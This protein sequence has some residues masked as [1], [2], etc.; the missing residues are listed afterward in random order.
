MLWKLL[1]S[2]ILLSVALVAIES[3]WVEY[4]LSEV[5]ALIVAPHGPTPQ[6]ILQAGITEN[7]TTVVLAA[8]DIANC[9]ERSGLADK[10]PNTMYL[11]GF[12]NA[13]D[14][15]S[16]MA[17]ETAAVA[18]EWP[19]AAILALGDTVYSKGRPVEYADCFDPVWGFLKSR[20]LPTPGN[21]EYKT[22][23]AFGYYD[24]FG[25]QAGPERHGW[26]VATAPGWL[27]LSLNS[28]ADASPGSPQSD[29]LRDRL[30]EAGGV[31]ILGF[32]HKPAHSLRARDG[33]ENAVNLFRQLQQAGAS[34]VLNGHNH[35]YEQT[36]PLDSYG[37]IATGLGT[38]VF[39]V[40]TGG[41][42]DDPI[43]KLPATEAA[44]FG[45]TGSLR[46]DLRKSSY[47]WAYV[48][49]LT[50]DVLDAGSRSC[51]FMR[52]DSLD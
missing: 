18:S 49:A 5:R 27:I 10:L 8:G 6:D 28:E 44:I 47:R 26:Y 21:H 1:A 38:V 40:G 45:R 3:G 35:F 31:C 13:L 37:E 20:I 19:D 22:P 32:Y 48:D 11:L 46:L 9:E 2:V 14:P 34:V 24:Y 15:T 51:N 30:D 17:N 36:A 41:V 43:L 12:E 50:G 29:W 39:T 52:L 25:A 42:I 23:G 33:R 4:V 7:D 16:A